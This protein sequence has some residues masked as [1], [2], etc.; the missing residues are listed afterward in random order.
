[1]E[2]LLDIQQIFS[3]SASFEQLLKVRN[4]RLYYK[5]CPPSLIWTM[6]RSDKK[7]GGEKSPQSKVDS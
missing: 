2:I 3:L 1:M 4:D 7:K 6:E 5:G